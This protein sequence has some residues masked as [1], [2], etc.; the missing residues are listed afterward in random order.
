MKK[1]TTPVETHTT[2][3]FVNIEVKRPLGMVALAEELE[4]V[5]AKE[6]E[7]QA[8][9]AAIFN[10][11]TGESVSAER[12]TQEFAPTFEVFAQLSRDINAKLTQVHEL[13]K[14]LEK[15]QRQAM[16]EALVEDRVAVAAIQTQLAD[17][18]TYKR[19]IESALR[20]YVPTTNIHGN[21]F[22]QG[23]DVTADA[24]RAQSRNR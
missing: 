20:E 10:Y 19:G 16:R 9:E 21:G 4:S 1:K 13:T 11:I 15:V 7:L 14:E 12:I 3:N 5:K 8:A 6:V 2:T 18:R 23:T 17:L 24:I 22:V